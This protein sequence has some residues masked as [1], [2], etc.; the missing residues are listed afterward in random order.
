VEVDRISL[1]LGVVFALAAAFYLWTAATSTPLTFD[2]GGVDRYNLLANA[3]LHFQLSVGHAPAGLLHLAEPYNPAQNAQFVDVGVN[4]A[5]NLH[6]DLLAGGNL[7]FLWGPAPA[8][9]LLV[10]LHLLG[11]E[12]SASVTVAFFAIA[13][14]GFALGT[15]RVLLAQIGAT[16]LWM[17]VLAA[18]TLAFCSAIPFLLR[19]P[20][21]TEDTIAGG[22]CFTMA[23]IWLAAS[24]LASDRRSTEAER[25]SPQSVPVATAAGRHSPPAHIPVSTEA[26]RH[27]P[28]ARIPVSASRASLP[29]LALMSLCFGLAA[30]SRPPLALAAVAL[31]PVYLA[32]RS[33]RPRRGLLMALTIPIGVC[34][35]LLAAYNQARFGDPLEFGIRYQLAGYDPLHERFG[36]LGYVPP[37]VW[38]Y[39]LSLP[40]PTAAFPFIVLGPPPLLYPVSLPANYGVETTGGLL[41]MTPILVFLLALP[42][43][44]RRRRAWLGSLA[45]PIVVLAGAGIAI[46][47][48]VSYENSATTERYAVEFSTLV[49][50]GALAAWLALACKARGGL[51]RLVRVGGGLLALWGCVMG[52]AIS[53][54][55]YGDFLAVNYPG[56]WAALQRV[57]SPLSAVIARVVG[58]PVLAEV[59][60]KHVSEYSPVSY[61]SLDLHGESSFWLDVGEPAD[62]A[63]VS[64]D[65]RTAALALNAS[66]GIER[67]GS[68]I[69]AGGPPVGVTVL[70]PKQAPAAYLVPSGGQTLHIPVRLGPGVNRFELRPLAGTF[71]LPNRSN[72]TAASVLVVSKVSLEDRY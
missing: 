41:P 17:C 56:T 15:L 25:V 48:L 10:P 51:R 40:R 72:P 42:W 70:G 47:L 55:G 44:W 61:T 27:S 54:I 26:G 69:E 43:I 2:N 22:F 35:L 14:M 20:S 16:T 8:L 38:F 66:P 34:F 7:Y 12:P 68:G 30:G 31:V 13:G 33:T 49:L 59:L 28:S 5:T 24:A 18:L 53:F 50:L 45:L 11:L 63:I 58:H 3:F 19:T 21:V 1:A 9:V 65:S 71:R 6:D 39:A 23:G 57:G 52:L 32:L 64:P 60:T 67:L 62:F 37:G 4:D 36:E 29:R 46:L